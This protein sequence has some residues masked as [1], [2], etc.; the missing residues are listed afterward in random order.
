VRPLGGRKI[1]PDPQIGLRDDSARFRHV[2]LAGP[3]GGDERV[4]EFVEAARVL[5]RKSGELL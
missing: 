3:G 5:T 1:D 2:D 4:M